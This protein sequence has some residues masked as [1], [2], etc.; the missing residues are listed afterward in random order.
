MKLAGNTYT[1]QRHTLDEL[2]ELIKDNQCEGYSC[3]EKLEVGVLKCHAQRERRILWHEAL[4]IFE[5]ALELD[6]T[7]AQVN[8]LAMLV[9]C[10]VQ[11]NK[12]LR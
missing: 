12:E 3:T 5:D 2:R 10:A 4:H 9:D 11:D 1:V 6:L 7:E 8:M